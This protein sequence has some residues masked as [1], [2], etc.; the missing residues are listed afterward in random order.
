MNANDIRILVV[1][2]FETMRFLLKTSLKDLGFNRVEEAAGGAEA[3]SKLKNGVQES[4]P[5][6]LML[7]DWQMPEV[8]GFD[9][10]QE[11][12]NTPQLSEMPIIMITSESEHNSVLQALMAGVTDYIV[13]PANKAIIRDKMVKIVDKILKAKAS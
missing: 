9:V 6:S 1:D 12:R 3:L 7:L 10:L 2:D 8:N 13:K 11:C 5:F 4:D